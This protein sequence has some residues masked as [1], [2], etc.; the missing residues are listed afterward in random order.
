L[1]AQSIGQHIGGFGDENGAE[2]DHLQDWFCWM[3][4]PRLQMIFKHKWLDQIRGFPEKSDE[5][6][7]M[8]KG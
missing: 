8:S 5:F 1:L 4:S 6:T 7:L 3:G 2:V